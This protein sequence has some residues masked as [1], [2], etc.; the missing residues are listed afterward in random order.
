MK[1]L[2]LKDWYNFIHYLRS[3]LF[4]IL[5][6]TMSSVFGNFGMFFAVYPVVMASII[7]ITLMTY[8]EKEHWNIYCLAMPYTR[9]QVVTAKYLE[10]LISGGVMSVLAVIAILLGAFRN[11]NPGDLNL[12]ALFAAFFL[13]GLLPSALILPLNFKFGT[14]KGRLMQLVTIGI[15]CGSAAALGGTTSDLENLAYLLNSPLI[16]VGIMV[17]LF[18]LS[19]QISIRIYNKKDL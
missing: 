16:L 13:V 19:W 5:I 9:A 17:L 12:V 15:I 4:L 7:P 11:G 6:F 10:C 14:T 3:F 8:D 2:L 18:F 1:G